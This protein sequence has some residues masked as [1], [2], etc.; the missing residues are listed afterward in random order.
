MP[1]SC[2]SGLRSRPSTGPGNSRSNGLDANSMNARNPMLISDITPSTRALIC[3]GKWPLNRLTA[4]I[5]SESISTHS[6]S[7]PS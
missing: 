5:H 4:T 7:E 3:N 1:G 6:S 2:S